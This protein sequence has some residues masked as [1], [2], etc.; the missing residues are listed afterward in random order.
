MERLNDEFRD[1]EKIKRSKE[2]RYLLKINELDKKAIAYFLKLDNSILEKDLLNLWA[3][4]YNLKGT[5][6]QAMMFVKNSKAML[7]TI[8][9]NVEI[10]SNE[11]K[12]AMALAHSK[13]A[14]K[15]LD[16][17]RNSPKSDFAE[18]CE[19]RDEKLAVEH[20]SSEFLKS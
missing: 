5:D 20:R 15:L 1:R 13:Y 17:I 8:N 19:T 14:Q 4:F 6:E 10:K 3:K 11:I 12:M 16:D 9:Q 7:Q 2:G 18:I